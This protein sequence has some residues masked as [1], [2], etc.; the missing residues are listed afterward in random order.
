MNIAGFLVIENCRYAG[1]IATFLIQR[2]EFEVD[3]FI[4]TIYIGRA[5]IFTI[6][7]SLFSSLMLFLFF[8]NRK[9]ITLS[10][11]LAVKNNL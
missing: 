8:E 5:M 2:Y 4:K 9:Y 3:W 6:Q 11:P 1:D 7:S 10:A